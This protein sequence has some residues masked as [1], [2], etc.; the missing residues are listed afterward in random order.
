[1]Y[2]QQM[3][4]HL[5]H[6]FKTCFVQDVIDGGSPEIASDWLQEHPDQVI[7][8]VVSFTWHDGLRD[9]AY[10]PEA[11]EAPRHTA[12]RRIADH[13]TAQTGNRFPFKF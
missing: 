8:L 10:P 5:R 11:D 2:S 1:M 9:Y 13:Y 6:V 7:Y 4:D 3:I 12:I